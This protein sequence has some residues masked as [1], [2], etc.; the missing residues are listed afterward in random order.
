MY[1]KTITISNFQCFAEEPT[2]INLEKDITCFV[3]NNGTGKSTIMHALQKIFGKTLLERNITKSDFHVS[4]PEDPIDN[5][6]LYIDVIFQFSDSDEA[7]K[8]FFAF[9]YED[10]KHNHYVRIRLEAEWTSNEYDDEVSSKLYWVLTKEYV[11]F[12]DDSELKVN[13]ENYERRLIDFIYVP[14]TRDAKCI[15]S[16]NMQKIIKE[17]E[18]YADITDI[19]RREIEAGSKELGDKIHKLPIINS[20]QDIIN[21]IWESLHDNTLAHYKKIKMEVVSSEFK[22][23]VKLL[24]IKLGPSEIDNFKTI[25]ELSDGQI[26][27]LYLALALSLHDIEL[28]H[29]QGLLDG[30]KMQDRELPVLTIIALEEPENHLS[31]FYLSKIIDVIENKSKEYGIV[32]LITSHSPNVVRRIN[33]VEQIRFLRQFIKAGD[34]QSSVTTIKLP[35]NRSED[36]YKFLNQ[37]VLAHPELYFAK[38]VILG[39]GDSEE[40]VLPTVARKLGMNLDTS[41]VSFVKLGGRHVN[42]MWRLLDELKIPYITLVDYDCGREGGGIKRVHDI[43]VLL[44]KEDLTRENLEEKNIY[45]SYPLDLDMM[46]IQAF[47]SFYEDKGRNS[48]HEALIKSVLGEDAQESQYT[49]EGLT[50]FNDGLLKKYRYLFKNKSKVA[51][52]YIACDKIKDMSVDDL[53]HALPD[54]LKKII[55]KAHKIIQ[56]EEMEY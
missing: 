55:D 54:V 25:D 29:E 19:Q 14:A 48:P 49:D 5:K 2:I 38:L 34:R 41:F 16:N 18:Y 12:G 17:I 39:E 31:P 33:K 4:S 53:K 42:H 20:I 23:L 24:K 9:I 1:I 37:A 7:E 27:L 30:A 43:N 44:E 36:D 3:G 22:D 46:M 8:P 47:P 11:E 52:H 21:N 45:F 13:V 26:S 50:I 28:K 32:G 51:S 40:I 6:Q 10:D 56:N 15:L 35:E